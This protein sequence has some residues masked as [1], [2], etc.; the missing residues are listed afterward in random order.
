MAVSLLL[1]FVTLYK[2]QLGTTAQVLGQVTFSISYVVVVVRSRLL[3]IGPEYEEAARDLGASPLGALRLVLLPLLAPAIFASLMV[4]F[5]LS[6]DDFVVTDYLSSNASTQ[7]VPIKIYS[8]VRGTTTPA[9]N[10]LATVMVVTTLLAVGLAYLVYR[11]FSVGPACERAASAVREH[12]GARR[13]DAPASGGAGRARRAP[14]GVRRRR[15]GR[16]HR[17]RRSTAG[18]FFSLLGPVRL[19]QDDDAAADRR[20]SSGRT[21]AGSCSTASTWPRRRRTAATSTRSSR[22][23]RSSRTSTS[24][25]T[26]PSGCAAGDVKR[27]EIARARA[28][29]C[30]RPCGSAGS[31]SAARHS[32]PAASSSASRSRGRSS[33]N[34]SVLLLDEPLGALDAKLRKALQLE[35]KSIQE[36]FG[37]TFVYVTHDQEEALTMS[38]R[39]AVMSGGRVEQVATPAEMYE[40]PRDGVRR[41]LPRRLEPDDGDGR[42]R[43]TAARAACGSASSRS[44]RSAA[45]SQHARRDADRDPP[46]AGPGRAVRARAGENR[47]PA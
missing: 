19:R 44:A 47:C 45:R 28:T 18:E 15:R 42:G 37:I 46:R 4:V 38:D 5:A 16:R 41:R 32:S 24:S 31:G 14:Q 8:S 20:A 36:Q 27:T 1:V 30:S 10:A 25:T 6:I 35:L 12:R 9:L 34:P 23:T 22:A 40:E 26:S 21:A 2:I 7:T 29:R 43:P 3:S 13:Y 39:I 33:S 17:P 11:Q